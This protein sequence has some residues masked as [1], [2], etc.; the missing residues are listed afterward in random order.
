MGW[1]SGMAPC[2]ADMTPVSPTNRTEA[3]AA[4]IPYPR[5]V[6]WGDGAVSLSTVHCIFPTGQG[7]TLDLTRANLHQMLDGLGCRLAPQPDPST[8]PVSLSLG[9]V[10]G[11]GDS[12]EAYRLQANPTDGIQ[13]TAPEPAGL[14]YGVQTLRQ[15]IQR[16]DDGRAQV[17]ACDITDW[18]AFGWRGF[19]HDLGRNYQDPD[20]LRRF[21]DVMA[22]YKM[23]VFHLHLTD[24]P[25]YRIESIRYPELN[26]PKNCRKGWH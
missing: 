5:Q 3:R 14:F 24:R 11:A 20:M 15:L 1:S 19:M 12:P 23:N 9:P 2:L 8:T 4:L 26:D 13:I 6:A 22:A 10:D 18:P 25:G 7:E 21:I 17:P 16:G